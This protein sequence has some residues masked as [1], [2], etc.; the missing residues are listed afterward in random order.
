M[1]KARDFAAI[2]KVPT[3][4]FKLFKREHIRGGLDLTRGEPYKRRSSS[5]LK[6][7]GLT[8]ER[9]SP[10]SLKEAAILGT[11]Y[12]KGWLLGIENLSPECFQQ[13]E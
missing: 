2:I 13:P 8:Q 1:A 5:V 3:Q 9:L 7:K 6:K 11:N 4:F 10:A 12:G